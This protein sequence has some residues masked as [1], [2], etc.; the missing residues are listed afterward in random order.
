[1]DRETKTIETP[2][3]GH[4]V[5]LKA[6][7][8]GRERRNLRKPFTEK[9][10]VRSGGTDKARVDIENTGDII[11]KVENSLIETIV[12]SVDGEREGV[13]DTV[14]DMRDTDFDSIMKEVDRIS[15]RDKD[16]TQPD[17][18]KQ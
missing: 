13:L 11:E 3:A 12:V 15:G 17:S 9:M 6:W 16:F 2:V 5:V 10:K 14:L 4:E 7:I 1:M 18:E 8:T